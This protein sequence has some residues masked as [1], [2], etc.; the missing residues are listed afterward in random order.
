MFPNTTPRDCYPD[1]DAFGDQGVA[2][3][4]GSEPVSTRQ[5]VVSPFIVEKVPQLRMQLRPAMTVRPLELL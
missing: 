1:F 3:A 4:A 5:Y 2:I